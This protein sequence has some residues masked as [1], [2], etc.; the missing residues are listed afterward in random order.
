MREPYWDTW[1]GIVIGAV[2]AIHACSSALAFPGGAGSSPLLSCF[3]NSSILR[4]LCLCSCR[5]C[6]RCPAGSTAPARLECGV[7]LFVYSC[8]T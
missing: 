5:V 3:D 7:G 8:P 6:L 4:W 2:V 1:K